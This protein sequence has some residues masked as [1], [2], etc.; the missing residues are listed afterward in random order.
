MVGNGGG[1]IVNPS[2]IAGII[3]SEHVHMAYNASKA[4]AR[5][6]TKS[7]AVQHA[8]DK[9]YQERF[10]T[11]W[12]PKFGQRVAVVLYVWHVLRQSRLIDWL[13]RASGWCDRL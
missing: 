12:V 6:R 11:L 4:A 5:L 7:V 13:L 8:K 9:I 2:S 3:G 1:S 10:N